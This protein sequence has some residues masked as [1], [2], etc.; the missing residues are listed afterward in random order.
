[1][2]EDHYYSNKGQEG[3]FNKRVDNS[4]MNSSPYKEKSEIISEKSVGKKN[5]KENVREDIGEEINH[6]DYGSNSGNNV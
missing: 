4:E 6:G 2:E 1:M 5:F 3:S